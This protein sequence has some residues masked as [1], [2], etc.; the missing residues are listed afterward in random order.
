MNADPLS[1][2]SIGQREDFNASAVLARCGFSSVQEVRETLVKG[3]RLGGLDAVGAPATRGEL[4]R[5][6]T[7]ENISLEVRE[8]GTDLKPGD[9]LKG[10]S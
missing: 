10:D 5:A 8:A 1:H 4:S 2:R 3:K 9:S 7:G 6:N